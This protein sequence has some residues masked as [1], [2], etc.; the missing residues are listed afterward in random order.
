MTAGIPRTDFTIS[1]LKEFR[2]LPAIAIKIKLQIR[3]FTDGD[4]PIY[5][6]TQEKQDLRKP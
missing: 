5:N 2:T 3:D 1:S 4:R 6:P